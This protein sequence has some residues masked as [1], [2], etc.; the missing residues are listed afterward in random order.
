[1]SS[2]TYVVCGSMQTICE[3]KWTAVS[4]SGAGGCNSGDEDVHYYDPGND[5][6]YTFSS[7][8]GSH[9]GVS[10]KLGSNNVFR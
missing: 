4:G 10:G 1:M 6:W 8:V 5:E 3:A 9:N 7:S 2:V